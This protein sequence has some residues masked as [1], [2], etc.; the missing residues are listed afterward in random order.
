[1][2]TESWSERSSVLARSVLASSVIGPSVMLVPVVAA[3]PAALASF[4]P[5][6][7]PIRGTQV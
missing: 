5:P 2:E 6:A 7:L 1:M 4:T 3:F